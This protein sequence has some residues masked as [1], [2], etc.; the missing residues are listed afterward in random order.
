M[1]FTSGLHGP[2]VI[3][4]MAKT[5]DDLV[6]ISV[7]CFAQDNLESNFTPMYEWLDTLESGCSN[8][9]YWCELRLVLFVIGKCTLLLLLLSAFFPSGV[10]TADFPS[11]VTPIFC[12]LLRQFN[13]SHVLFHH[14]RKHP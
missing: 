2:R 4:T 5:F 3:L 9:E 1:S 11:P 8:S 13:L 10:A 14:I 6:D 7:I 12:I